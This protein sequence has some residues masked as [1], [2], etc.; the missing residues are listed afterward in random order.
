MEN[1]LIYFRV[2]LHSTSGFYAQ[3][4]GKVDVYAEDSKDAELRAIRELQRTSFPDRSAA[5]WRVERVE[6]I[7]DS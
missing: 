2:W 6:R 4:D 1:K 5:M 3:Y 7:G